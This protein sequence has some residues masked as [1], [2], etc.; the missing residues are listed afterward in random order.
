MKTASYCLV[1]LLVPLTVTAPCNA[2]PIT[3]PTAPPVARL[4]LT[5]DLYRQPHPQP[6]PRIRLPEPGDLIPDAISSG[7]GFLLS[8][9]VSTEANLK[10]GSAAGPRLNLSIGFNF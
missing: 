2:D 6:E 10:G 9:R 3:Q 5:D 4:Q 7:I 8:D 1:P